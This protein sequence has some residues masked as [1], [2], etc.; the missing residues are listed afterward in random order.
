MSD[1]IHVSTER[2]EC[3][4]PFAPVATT[5]LPDIVV[6]TTVD[7]SQTIGVLGYVGVEVI[8]RLLI[9]ESTVGTP[10]IKNSLSVN[11]SKLS[12]PDKL[13]NSTPAEPTPLH[14]LY[15]V[16]GIPPVST[17]DVHEDTIGRPSV[18]VK[19]VGI[20]GKIPC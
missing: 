16:I 6:P 7:V 14:T 13:G 9:D 10:C 3:D 5:E 19:P 8:D 4:Q 18:T 15:C 2:A 11:V 17:G 1:G 20:C 12:D